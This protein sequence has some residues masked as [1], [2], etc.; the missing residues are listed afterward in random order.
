M[1]VNKAEIDAVLD[2]QGRFVWTPNALTPDGHRNVP[3]DLQEGES[4]LAFL[5]RHVPGIDSGAWAVKIGGIEIP[6]RMWGKTYPKHGMHIACRATVGKQA[7]QLVAVAALAYFSGGLAAGLYGAK[8]G[9]YV[10]A[11]AGLMRCRWGSLSQAP[12]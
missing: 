11:N 8:G 3:C 2:A 9:S 1:E 7:V 5:R 4:L 6:R 10:A 12:S